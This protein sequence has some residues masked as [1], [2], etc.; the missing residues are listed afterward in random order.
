MTMH[1]NTWRLPVSVDEDGELDPEDL[2]NLLAS[3]VMLGHLLEQ[4]LHLALGS[5]M[6]C[7]SSRLLSERGSKSAKELASSRAPVLMMFPAM[8]LLAVANRVKVILTTTLATVVA[9]PSIFAPLTVERER[10]F[11]YSLR[12]P[13]SL[14]FSE[15][16][17]QMSLQTVWR[18]VPHLGTIKRNGKKRLLMMFYV[19]REA[20]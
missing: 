2:H 11:L 4:H 5:S 17:V 3:L 8:P 14:S 16:W 10:S 12:R 7:S 19:P 9:T 15:L 18:V 13:V 20:M 1:G 6:K